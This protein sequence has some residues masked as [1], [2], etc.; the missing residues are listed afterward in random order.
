MGR[1]TWDSLPSNYRPLPKRLNVIITN[2]D[3]NIKNDN[4]VVSR[5]ENFEETI[6]NHVNTQNKVK[7][8]NLLINDIYIIGG[9]QI[10]NL[11]LKTRKLNRIYATEIY[12][13]VTCDTFVANYLTFKSELNEFKSVMTLL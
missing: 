12:K 4:V 1:K 5:W 2:Q 9:Q 10:Y 7:K 6:I 11:A 13:D 3:L 8:R